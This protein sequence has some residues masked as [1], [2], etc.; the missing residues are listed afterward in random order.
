MFAF[1]VALRTVFLLTW[2][3]GASALAA[4]R[5][6]PLGQL[7][8]DAR[9]LSYQLELTVLPDRAGF[10]GTARIVVSLDE[11]TTEIWLHG[12][13][14]E[15]E[16]AA[17]LLA[18]G[19]R[20]PA[21]YEEVDESG[22]ALLTA[23]RAVG[24]GE[25]TLE[26]AYGAPYNQSLVGLYQV[27]EDGEVYAFS[28][29]QPLDARRVFPG[30]DEPRFKTPFD[31]ALT[32]RDGDSAISNA[33]EIGSEPLGGG[34]KR[35]RFQ[36]TEPLP[37]YLVAFAV[38]PFDVVT[39]EPIPPTPQRAR[40]IPLRG[41]AVK[42]KGERFRYALEETAP[43]MAI[44]EDYFGLAYPYAKLDLVAV[45]QFNSGGMENAGAIFYRENFLLF[46]DNPSIYQKR[47]FAGIHAHELAHS[48]FGNFV[49]PAWW[50]DLWLNESFATWM[51]NKVVSLW[52]PEMFDRRG[53]L[54]GAAGAMWSDR[55]PSARAIRQ[56]ILTNHDIS[57][58][59][60]RIT[61]SKG[62]GVLSMFERYMG[63]EAFR[64]G[65]R[66][67]IAA[68]PHGVATAEDFMAALS[69]AAEDHGLVAAKRSFLD[70][71]GIPYLDVAWACRADSGAEIRLRQSR[72][73]PPGLE[74]EGE[75]SWRLPLCLAYGTEGERERHC[76]LLDRPDVS[77]TLE[78]ESC[79]A[80]LLPNEAGAGYLLW[81]LSEAGWEAL[82]ANLDHL[83]AAEMLSLIH[84]ASAAYK[85]GRMDLA[86]YLELAAHA[87]ASDDWDV[88]AAPMQTLR[89]VKLFVVPR[90]LRP[91]LKRLYHEIYRPALAHF[92][93]SEESLARGPR[94]SEEAL[95]FGDLVWF[96]AIDADDPLPRALLSRL[97]QAYL[98]YGG[99]GDLHPEVLNANLVRA[100][101]IVAAQEVGLPFVEALIDRLK[102]TRDSVL[103]ANI[104]AALAYQADPALVARIQDFILDPALPK[105][106]ASR[107]LYRQARRV[108]NRDAV[109]D[110]FRSNREAVLAKLP[111]THRGG[112]PWLAQGFCSAEAKAEVARYFEPLV[113]DWRGGPRSL[114]QVL[115]VVALCA[116]LAELQG[117][118]AAA[119][120]DRH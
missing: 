1:R 18:D 81:S 72:Y 23:E 19:T 118:D 94:S 95:L 115:D 36:T 34:L 30:F 77:L 39:W 87:A 114:A 17:V 14:L 9:P 29:F 3:A 58:A 75:K 47:G 56:P 31:I 116:A 101:L 64:D 91:K 98:G 80:W 113:E 53:S 103:R 40:P 88:V 119:Y 61:Y 11:A 104:V 82:T 97:G 28:D 43:M 54:R 62:G 100:A 65:V 25:V 8:E 26:I 5:A 85:S 120:L 78:T 79:P 102:R 37:T 105:R 6:I 108:D 35:V 59:F 57:N 33:P 44:L 112:L 68:H 46:G 13:D 60:D 71:P 67:Y 76:L 66:R 63:E 24:P 16:R 42:G 110:W 48:W 96:L 7:P 41:I 49:T 51:A 15:V 20:L 22:V 83:S 45:P 99:D 92:E 90:A 32:V 12:Q 27:E 107:I 50:N 111:E 69:E 93:M 84:S 70:Q 73:V 86:R 52:D 2:L 74:A 4:E 55:L 38:G 21:R 106:E 109:W 10:F 117:A 89:E